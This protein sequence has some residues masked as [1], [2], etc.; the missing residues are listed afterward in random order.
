MPLIDVIS[1][2]NPCFRVGQRAARRLAASAWSGLL[3]INVPLLSRITTSMGCT[4]RSGMAYGPH[5]ENSFTVIE[6]E[7]IVHR[8]ALRIQSLD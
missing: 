7:S 5:R 1:G 8:E 3:S 6:K 4:S 2:S